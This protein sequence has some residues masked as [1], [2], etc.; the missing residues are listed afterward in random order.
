MVLLVSLVVLGIVMVGL[1]FASQNT[2]FVA[3]L[4]RRDAARSAAEAGVYRVLARLESEPAFAGSLEEKLPNSEASFVA[5]MVTNTLSN[6]GGTATVRSTGQAGRFT[7][8]LE[9]TLARSGES[10][11]AL[12]SDGFIRTEGDTYAN[13]IKGLRNAT[14]EPVR[15]H[16]NS[17]ATSAIGATGHFRVRG[18]AS[19]VG[20]MDAGVEADNRLPG[21]SAQSLSA[22]DKDRLLSGTFTEGSI[23][24]NGAVASN[25]RVVGDTVF[26]GALHLQNG[27]TLHVKEGSLSVRGGVSGNGAVVADKE[28]RIR[29]GSTLDPRNLDGVT[30][31]G[32]EGVE[33]AHPTAVR[34]GSGY[35][36]PPDAI[37]DFFARMP[38]AARYTL[39]ENL[40]AGAPAGADFFEW[41]NQKLQNPDAEFRAWREGSGGGSSGLSPE[42]RDWLDSSGS[43]ANDLKAWGSGGGAGSSP[44]TP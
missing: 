40:P 39:A 22:V 38:E 2:L 12:S 16:A 7:K 21:G 27:A 33:I 14:G 1:G 15:V 25:L 8:T 44:P 37:A 5:R 26:E 17:S 23:P 29:A 11:D 36:A 4:H 9:V 41:Y 10:F 43:I 34:T 19:A 32:G 20:G 30:L 31:Y 13:G 3:S 18:T 24:G 28:L 6:P 42:V 35:Q